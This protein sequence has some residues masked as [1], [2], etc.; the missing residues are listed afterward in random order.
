MNSRRQS[1]SAREG[2]RVDESAEA[3]ELTTID[4][5]TVRMNKA[6]LVSSVARQSIP[7]CPEGACVLI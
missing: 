1:T 2:E 4:D 7:A 6:R 3:N 5:N